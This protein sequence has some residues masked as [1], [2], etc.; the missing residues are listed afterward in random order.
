MDVNRLEAL[1][2]ES[3]YNI[4]ETR[5]IVNGFRKGFDICYQGPTNR[6]DTSR[7]LPFTVGN[8][9]E[10]FEKVMEEV[11]L[12]RIAGPF[13]RIPFRNFIQSPIGLVPKAGNKTRMIF[14]L[15]YDFKS[16][17]SVNHYIPE[18]LCTVK[19]NDL[20]VAVKLIL[21]K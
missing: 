20:D 19:Y 15:S 4:N 2:L 3:N 8:K 18:E 11:K 13:K 17:K 7:N 9:R 1:L 12:K 21:K 10:L 16:Y 14:H 6:Q 5:F